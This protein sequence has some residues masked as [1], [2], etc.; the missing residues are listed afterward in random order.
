[1][2]PDTGW[3]L[4][5]AFAMTDDLWRLGGPLLANRSH[6]QDMQL[7]NLRDGNQRSVDTIYTD[8]F[9]FRCGIYAE[10][11]EKL[12][13]LVCPAPEAAVAAAAVAAAAATVQVEEALQLP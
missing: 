6:T 2:I 11:N 9:H 10:L 3:A 8:N 12:L 4:L 5:D 13:D 1:M 7:R